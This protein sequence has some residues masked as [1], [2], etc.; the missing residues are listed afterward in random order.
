MEQ[1]DRGGM[2]ARNANLQR[3]KDVRKEKKDLKGK[4]IEDGFFFNV[5]KLECGTG[6]F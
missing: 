3:S 6:M 4:K 5:D 1:L 2:R